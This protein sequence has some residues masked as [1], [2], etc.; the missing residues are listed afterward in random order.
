[1][2][3]ISNFEI[4]I[5]ARLPSTTASAEGGISMAIPPVAIIGPMA[6]LGWYPRRSISGSKMLPSIAVLAM[7]DPESDEKIV[8][9]I[10]DTMESLPGT[11]E[12]SLSTVSI[13]LSAS[14]V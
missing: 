10:T 11:R 4:D 12:M 9:L 6:I 2:P 1:M 3:A 14:P 5:P 8:P 7:V 13:A